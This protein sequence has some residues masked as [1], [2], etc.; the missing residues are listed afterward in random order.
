MNF[1]SSLILWECECDAM[2]LFI[3]PLY[4]SC[5]R[6]SRHLDARFAHHDYLFLNR[7][8]LTKDQY[9]KYYGFVDLIQIATNKWQLKAIFIVSTEA[10]VNYY[11]EVEAD[12]IINSN[13]L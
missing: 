7:E 13:A 11:R 5:V 10:V 4:F 1:R 12:F 8:N 3:F 6:V 9:T 2:Y